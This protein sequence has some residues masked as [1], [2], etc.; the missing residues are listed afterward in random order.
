MAMLTVFNTNSINIYAGINGLEVGQS[1]IIGA[2][3]FAHNLLEIMN[4]LATEKTIQEHLLS[5]I[6][7]LPFL[8]G[9]LALLKYNK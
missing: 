9:S 4:P 5:V 8:F 1:L 3:V 6:I 2:S 7:I